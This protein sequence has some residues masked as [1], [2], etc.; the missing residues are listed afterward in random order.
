[1]E[2]KR[3]RNVHSPLEKSLIILATILAAG[4]GDPSPGGTANHD[5]G[6]FKPIDPTVAGFWDRQTTEN[7]ELLKAIAGEFNASYDGPPIKVI[8]SGNYADIYTKTIAAIRARTLPAMAVA[9]G[10]MTVEYAKFDAVVDIGELMNDPDVGFTQDEID[11]FF[12]AVL[13]QNRYPDLD[14]RLFSFPYTKAVLVMYCNTD[15]MS[16]AGLKDPPETW[17]DF[18]AQCRAIKR[19]TGK[20]ALCF[21]VDASTIN[22]MIFSRGGE[23]IIDGNLRYDTPEALATLE[24]LDT[25]FKEKLAYQNPPRTFSDQTAFGN[26]NIAFSFRPSSSRPYYELVKEGLD[27][28]LISPIP[29]ADPV[30]PSTVLYGANISIFNTTPEQVQSAWAFTKFF[31]SVEMNVRWALHTGY[32]PYRKSAVDHP[33]LQ[34]YWAKWPYNRTAFDCLPSAR[35]EPNI[36]GWQEVRRYAENAATAVITGLKTAGEAVATLQ[37]EVDALQARRARPN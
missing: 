10:N 26:N 20:P 28:W 21:D 12:P 5:P 23:I 36:E 16:A 19:Q 2:S 35:P 3:R 32:L 22:G 15:V 14:N 13:E 9:Y 1:M 37:R 17:D 24:F 4:C 27:G 11:D 7:A 33:D 30:H 34:A 18:L 29:Q 25:L 31:T 6:R 8:Q